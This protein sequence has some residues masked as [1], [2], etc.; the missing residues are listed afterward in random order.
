MYT[1]SQKMSLLLSYHN[2]DVRESILI[3]FGR[4]LSEKVR[5]KK[6]LYFSTSPN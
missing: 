4:S 3:I 6:M 2:Y 1:V 5:N